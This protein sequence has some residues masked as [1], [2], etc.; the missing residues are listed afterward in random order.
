MNSLIIEGYRRPAGRSSRTRPLLTLLIGLLAWTTSAS[1]QSSGGAQQID[2]TWDDSAP[3]QGIYF[4]WYEPSFYT[5]FAP[6]TQDPNRVHIELSR[7]NQ[8]RFTLGRI[9]DEFTR[10]RDAFTRADAVL[11]VEEPTEE[12]LQEGL[13]HFTEATRSLLLANTILGT[14]ELPDEYRAAAAVAPHCID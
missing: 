12:I 10:A 2:K 5:G 6:G 14:L 11:D 9:V 3:P 4:H 1:A 13:R 7:G 8:V